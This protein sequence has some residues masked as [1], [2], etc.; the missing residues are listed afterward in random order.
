MVTIGVKVSASALANDKCCYIYVYGSEDGTNYNASSVEAVGT[1]IA[2]TPDVPSNMS[3]PV[4]LACPA[5]ASGAV[6]RV[7][8]DV[9]K[10]LGFIPRKWGLVLRNYTGQALDATEANHQKTYTGV[11]TTIS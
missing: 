4:I 6:Y 9:V 11:G 5:A 3:G 1:D 10:V 8:F 7:V 2:V